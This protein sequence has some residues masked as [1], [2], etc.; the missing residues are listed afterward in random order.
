MMVLE[1]FVFRFRK[2]WWL[3]DDDG[4]DDADHCKHLLN[5]YYILRTELGVSC[6]M[7]T[8]VSCLLCQYISFM[9]LHR[10]L[11]QTQWLNT[12]YIYCLCFC[13]SGIWAQLFPT[14]PSSL[15][16]FIFCWLLAWGHPQFPEAFLSS[17]PWGVPN[18]AISFLTAIPG[19]EKISWK[20]NTKSYV[21]YSCI[22]MT[23]IPSS[24][25]YSIA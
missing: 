23:Y 19:R 16:W 13:V 20:T 8:S 14:S 5:S 21:M 15:L 7:W 10:K 3:Y 24:F 25:L 12:T 11:P 17:L 4:D 18:M 22:L 1:V 9:L 6:S 2:L